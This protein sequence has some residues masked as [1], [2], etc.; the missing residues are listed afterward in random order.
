MRKQRV[1]LEHHVDGA[2]VRQHLGDVAAAEQDAALIRRL[3]A[4]EHA[5][6]RG[7]AAAARPEQ[8]EELAGADVEREL[9]DRAEIPERLGDALDPQQRHVRDGRFRQRPR[10]LRS[11]FACYHVRQPRFPI[12]SNPGG[13]LAADRHRLNRLTDISRN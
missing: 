11:R 6:Q 9:V 3:E 5:Q 13:K 12:R 4:G 7:L 2:L 1:V 8:R 10:R